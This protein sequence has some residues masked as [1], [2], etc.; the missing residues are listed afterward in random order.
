MIFSA[1]LT[2]F[3]LAGKQQKVPEKQAVT[4]F[5]KERKEAMPIHLRWL[6]TVPV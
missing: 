5:R 2:E 4:V 3:R 6:L 1:A